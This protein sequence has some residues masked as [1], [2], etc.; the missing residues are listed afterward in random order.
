MQNLMKI[1]CQTI[2][3]FIPV[4]LE[5]IHE[6]NYTED[7]NI[8]QLSIIKNIHHVIAKT[9]KP[10]AQAA[11]RGI[12]YKANQKMRRIHLR[13]ESYSVNITQKTENLCLKYYK[14][15]KRQNSLNGYEA[16][17]ETAEVLRNICPSYA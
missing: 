12:R 4:Q 5:H 11:I 2:L 3:A 9:L 7:N 14:L 1:H 13:T 15:R 8:A 6:A 16:K 10:L 17:V